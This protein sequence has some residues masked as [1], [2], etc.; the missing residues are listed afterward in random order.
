LGGRAG[1]PGGD[2][3]RVLV[4]MSEPREEHVSRACT[5]GERKGQVGW[6]TKGSAG[7]KETPPKG[8]EKKDPDQYPSLKGEEEQSSGGRTGGSKVKRGPK[9]V[10]LSRGEIR[11]KKKGLSS[12]CIL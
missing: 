8:R 9:P 4:G 3:N 6:P 7:E 10:F 11:A 1:L 2:K 12:S 5:A